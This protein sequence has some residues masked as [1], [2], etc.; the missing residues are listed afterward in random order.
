MHS[1][2]LGASTT[3][4]VREYY[5]QHELGRVGVDAYA[6]SLCLSL[7][8][9]SHAPLL[10]L[11]IAFFLSASRENEFATTS[12]ATSYLQ[13]LLLLRHSYLPRSVLQPATDR[14]VFLLFHSSL[15]SFVAI[16]ATATDTGR[17]AAFTS[18]FILTY[19]YLH[20]FLLPPPKLLAESL[21]ASCT[22]DV[23]QCV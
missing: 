10:S 16:L 17:G 19:L 22:H 15:S 21:Y 13:H 14:F 23:A 3:N 7:S 5:V 20:T 18:S 6:N 11:S 1:L 2:V 12:A 9:K 4:N 8:R